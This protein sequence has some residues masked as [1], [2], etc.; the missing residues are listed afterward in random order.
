M[1]G[2]SPNLAGNTMSFDTAQLR[3]QN[4]RLTGPR[5]ASALQVVEWFGAI[6]AQD[7][8]AALWA[9]G[10]RSAGAAFMNSWYPVNGQ[11]YISVST[12]APTWPGTT[13][14]WE[15]TGIQPD[16]EV[17]EGAELARVE[18]LLKRR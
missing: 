11:L 14:N 9:V 17:A 16:Y 10:Q 8:G 4:Q 5:P 7:F 6:Q 13:E 3:C 15:A 2:A 12:G 18:E 1:H